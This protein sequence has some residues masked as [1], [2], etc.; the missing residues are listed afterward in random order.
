V[1]DL[2]GLEE[3]LFERAAEAHFIL[4]DGIVVKSNRHARR[5]FHTEDKE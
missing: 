3:K 1:K 4:K 5:I 2:K